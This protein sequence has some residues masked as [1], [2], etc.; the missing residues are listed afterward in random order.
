MNTINGKLTPEKLMEIVGKQPLVPHREHIM[1]VATLMQ[2]NLSK[3][4]RIALPESYKFI[5]TGTKYKP[6]WN[7]IV[8]IGKEVEFLALLDMHKVNV[9]DDFIT[10][11]T[12]MTK[13]DFITAMDEIRAKQGKV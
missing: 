6:E 13:H 12:G 10:K 8:P 2:L 9:P 7:V 4:N 5:N 1:P 3:E 11:Y